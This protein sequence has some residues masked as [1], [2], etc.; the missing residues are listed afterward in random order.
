MDMN[1][2]FFLR[3]EDNKPAWKIIDAKDR[4]LGRLATQIADMLRGKDKPVY[5]P[6]SD[7]GDYVVVINADKVKL[8]GDKLT[9]KEY[10]RY[11]GYMGGYKVRTAKEML[12]K[13]PTHLVEHAVKGMLPKNKLSR[14]MLKKLKVYA[15]SEHPHQAQLTKQV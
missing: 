9:D 12:E 5:T 6:H 13:H 15:G 7:A 4:V 8:T 1:K 3:K 14:A 2:T 10:D 11:S